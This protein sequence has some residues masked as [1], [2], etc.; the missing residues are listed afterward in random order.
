MTEPNLSPL[1]DFRAVFESA[2]GAY[3]VL[4]RDLTIVAASDSYLRATMTQRDEI[5]GQR[6]FDLFPKNPADPAATGPRDLR[7]SFEQVLATRA[8]DTL[9]SQR[10]DI[11]RP[12]A[13]GGGFEV[14]RWGI[15]NSPVIDAAGEVAWIIHQVEERSPLQRAEDATPRSFL[16]AVFENI[17]N[18]VFVK[19]AESLAFVEMNRA[20]ERLLGLPRADLIGKTDYD[21]FS[22]EQ[23]EFFQARDRE[24]LNSAGL[25]EILEEPIQTSQ[26]LR[27][28]RTKKVPILDASGAPRFLLGISEDITDSLAAEQ[29]RA[30]LAAIIESSIDAVVS[31]TLDGIITSWNPAAARIYG[32]T[33]QE[34][35]GQPMMLV[36]PSECAEEEAQLVARL[37]RGESVEYFETVRQ[38]KDGTRFDVSLTISPIRDHAGEMVGASTI[39]RDITEAKRA[40]AKAASLEARASSVLSVIA[41]GVLV[42][43][44]L[45]IVSTFS[46]GAERIFGYRAREVLGKNVKLLMP[47]PDRSRH[48]GYLQRYHATG[49][50]RLI[51]IGREVLG[52][53]KDGSRVPLDISVTEMW[54]DGERYYTGV[55]RDISERKL[56]EAALAKKN[57][58]LEAAARADRIGARVMVALNQPDATPTPG[59]AVLQILADEAGYRHLS[60][61]EFDEWQSSLVLSAALSL[62]PS[63]RQASFK[64]GQGLIGE[65]AARREPIFLE[66]TRD[67]PFSLD[68]GAGEGEAGCFFALPL[69]HREQLLGVMAGT[70]PRP[71][72]ERERSWLAHVTGQVAI[73]LHATR[74]LQELKELS[75]Q[76]NER[77]RKIENQNRELAKAN[78]LKSEFLASMSHELRTPLN[79]IIGFSEV[80]KDGLLGEL[81]AEQLD[82][83][84]EIFQSGRH[85]LSLINDILDLSKIEAG[86]TELDIESVELGPLLNNALTIIKERAAKGGVRVTRSIAPELTSIEADGRKLRQIVYNL[87]SNAVKFTPSGGSV[88]VEVTAHGV[89]VE[90]AV[91]DSGIG[92]AV[93]EQ[94]R[95]FRAFEQLDSGIDRKYEGTGLGLVMVKGLVELH[96]GTLGVVSTPGVGS[97]FWVRLPRSRSAAPTPAATSGGA[98][99]PSAAQL[100]APRVLV[101]DDDRAALRLA[102]QWLSK[103]GYL[104]NEATTCD[105]AWEHIQSS[106]PD[107][108]L[109]DILFENGPSGWEFLERLRGAPR[110]AKIPVVIVS[111]VAELKRGLALGALEVLQKP[112]SGADLLRAVEALG[113]TSSGTDSIHVLVVDDDP[114][115]VEHVTQRIEQRGMLVTRAYGGKE[116]LASLSAG[117][118]SAVVLDLMMP[119]VSGFDVV[120][121]VRANPATA[122][123]PIIVLTAKLLEPSERRALENSVSAVLAKGEWDDTEFLRVVRAAIT[124]RRQGPRAGSAQQ[125]SAPQPGPRPEK[126]PHVLVIDDD[127]AARDLLRLYLEDAGFAVTA[128]AGADDAFRQLNGARPDLITLDPLASGQ[129]GLAFVQACSQTE[130]LRGLPVLVVSRENGPETAIGLGAS[131]VLLKPIRRHEFL[132]V[133]QG[134]L[135]RGVQRRPYVVV[136][137]DDPRAVK[138]IT[139]YFAD[140]AVDVGC[141]YGGREALELVTA[142][143]PDVLILD[144]IMPGL[145][146]FDVLAQLRANAATA[147]LPIVILSA[148]ELTPAERA[149]LSEDVQAVL[150]KA[151][152]RRG[153]LVEQVRRLLASTGVKP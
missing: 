152:T 153:D 76:L 30:R 73:G 151:T 57:L 110:V 150:T 146:G 147:E 97:R 35:I 142:R 93:E 75:K 22:K 99:A 127:V 70:S 111:I 143:C 87:L 29:E 68:A 67:A 50:A 138:L 16:G 144:L 37:V 145:S 121:E 62:T 14:R 128:A 59:A 7:A 72:A 63:D 113:L 54:I 6:L 103:E 114:R 26:G 39:A 20:G 100:S 3:L 80:L 105:Q 5:L 2:P 18:M 120:R 104:I 65:A 15:T 88:S 84:T 116:A 9:A 47:E 137:D 107:V 10:Y 86:K 133:V 129:G 112:V 101:V 4:A 38:R 136:A 36:I 77:S 89:D 130:Q 124:S 53:R 123:L 61:Y 81:S 82:Y 41:D 56:A 69:L 117:S 24:T 45:G 148:Q 140:G 109:L 134:L 132:A 96:G 8:P 95:L 40:A 27:M 85:L 23:A 125:L 58:E 43:D 149:A 78:R 21:F 11:R 98:Q 139:S 1:P 126:K 52:A 33:A 55:L 92:I 51:G 32:Y 94:P 42:I 64:I 49:E 118:F 25:I 115:A 131:A 74:Q 31:K 28:L 44:E 48:D 135:S 66:G 71:L 90:I 79:A 102:R 91:I 13:E 19:D 108:I 60:L 34:A 106:S 141:A 83:A 17:P 119:G 12:A 122:Q 46:R